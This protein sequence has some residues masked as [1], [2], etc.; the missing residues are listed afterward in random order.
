M[1]K[2]LGCCIIF[3]KD[4][5]LF[6]CPKTKKGTIN[7][8]KTIFS[9]ADIL[10]PKYAPTSEN[11]SKWAVI[12]CDQFTS[13]IAYWNRV[14]DAVKD[15]IS[16]YHY[17]LPE[18][19]LGKEKESAHKNT[20]ARYMATYAHGP[21]QA[22]TPPFT[23]F[24]YIERT[25]TDGKVR[26]GI[27]GAVDLEEYD[28][29]PTSTSPIRATEETVASRIPPRCAMRRGATVEL[30]HIMVFAED[31]TGLFAKAEE[32]CGRVLYDFEL[33]EGGG[34]IKGYAVEGDACDALTAA[35]AENEAAC[36]LPYAM[37]DGNHSL[38]SA[39]MHYEEIKAELGE[40]A[41]GHPARYAL[42]EVV[43]ISDTAIE[44]EPIHRIVTGVSKDELIA[45]LEK[46]AEKASG[47]QE[48]RVIT[49][50]G[51]C[52][53]SFTETSHSMA[54]GTLQN[55]IDGYIASHDGAECDYIHGEEEL[56]ALVS[57]SSVAFMFDG[58][59]KSRLF[60]FI[61]D[62]PLP[63]KT[64]SMGDARSKRYYLEARKIVK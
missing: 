52:V 51:E 14:E 34:H 30:P 19:Y 16:T 32:L 17:I 22:M 44:F 49:D 21:L 39:K 13:D 6:F 43:S 50:S 55:F 11:F 59:D 1:T 64:F 15:S 38:A 4:G 40:D 46:I 53:Y 54:V 31:R 9:K 18:A 28:Y 56:K 12:A 10:L 33:M 27:L 48:V 26:H 62:G 63:R 36:P 45:A 20:V 42:C 2:E 60:E 7:V 57:E 41:T 35:I 25:L 5:L 3:L 24:I 58:F 8:N 37:G 23:G 61:K 47:E 29:S